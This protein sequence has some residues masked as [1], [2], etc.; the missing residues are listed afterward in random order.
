MRSLLEECRRLFG[1]G[2][3]RFSILDWLALDQKPPDWLDQRNSLHEVYR[4]QRRIRRDG[5]VHWAGLTQANSKMFEPGEGDLPAVV[6][7]G[8]DPSWD[9]QPTELRKL[10]SALFA[11][12]GKKGL[13]GELQRLVDAVSNERV[14]VRGDAALL[15]A[16]APARVT[17]MM[18][19]RRSLPVPF[20][21]GDFFPV[22]VLG[23]LPPLLLPIQYW[24]AELRRRWIEP[25]LPEQGAGSA[26]PGLEQ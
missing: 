20:L 14:T 2:P 12:K 26:E 19:H 10:A 15:G 13:G 6:V 4:E 3:R 18:V 8:L 9:D 7:V 1:P 22:V 24:A 11:L 17:E 25:Y 21:A 5:A 23:E 16:T